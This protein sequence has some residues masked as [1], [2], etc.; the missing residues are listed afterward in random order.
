MATVTHTVV[1]GDTLS[2]LARKYNTTV[3]NIAKLNN[4]KNS[5]Y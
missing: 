2:A 4:I 3:N 1:K 5:A